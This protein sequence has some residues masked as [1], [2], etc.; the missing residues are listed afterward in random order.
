M[1]QV[2]WKVVECPQR[3][4]RYI[5]HTLKRFRVIYMSLCYNYFTTS[6]TILETALEPMFWIVDHSTR[7]LGII[8]VTIV[9]LLT[10]MVVMVTYICIFPHILYQTDYFWSG[11]HLVFSHWLLMNIVFNYVMAAFTH[12]G[13]PPQNVSEVVSICKKCIAPKPPRTHHCSICGKCV[14]KMDHHCPWLNNCVGYYNHRYF[15]QFIFYMWLGTIY[16]TFAGYDVFKQHFFGN[17]VCPLDLNIKELFN[18]FFHNAIVF[19]FVLCAGVSVALGLL[20][21][22]HARLISMGQTSIE[23]HVNNKERARLKKKNKV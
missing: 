1:A 17:K 15:L 23:V 3:L 9:V 6:N 8:M 22:W 20:F 14:L 4:K 13:H 18:Q 19:E 10:T 12:P 21:F 2:H 16:S 5:R 11:V 7:Y